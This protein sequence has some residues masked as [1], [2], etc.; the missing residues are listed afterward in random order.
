MSG[1]SAKAYLLR[2]LAKRVYTTGRILEKLTRKGV[3]AED[4]EDLIAEFSKMGYL[5][6]DL[7]TERSSP[8]GPEKDMGPVGSK[9]RSGKRKV[10]TDLIR[11][12]PPPPPPPPPP[13]EGKNPFF[14]MR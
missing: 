6:D 9:T 5:D 2:L 7:Y 8:R 10:P 1:A 12:A 4:K 11:A 3:S 14:P 13:L